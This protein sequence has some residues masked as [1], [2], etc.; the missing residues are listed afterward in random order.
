MKRTLEALARKIKEPSEFTPTLKK[1]IIESFFQLVNKWKLNDLLF[2]GINWSR[3]GIN[4]RHRAT[5]KKLFWAVRR[6]F[7][8]SIGWNGVDNLVIWRCDLAMRWHGYGQ[9]FFLK[10]INAK[11]HPSWVAATTTSMEFS[12]T[13]LLEVLP[14]FYGWEQFSDSFLLFWQ[15]NSNENWN[16][17]AC[18]F[19]WIELKFLNLIELILKNS[20]EFK[21]N[22]TKMGCNLV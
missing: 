18:N 2:W 21:F 13:R 14:Y 6:V 7:G 1:K 22:W 20:N 4:L 5:C 3:K 10:Q 8:H 11:F 17:I 16:D 9:V 12:P 19:T 15:V